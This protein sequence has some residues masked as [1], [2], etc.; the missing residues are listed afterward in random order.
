[1]T[2]KSIARRLAW[3]GMAALCLA[4]GRTAFADDAPKSD[5][6]PMAAQNILWNASFECGVGSGTWGVIRRVGPNVPESWHRGGYRSA[7]CLSLVKPI[8]SRL[9]KIGDKPGTWRL[10]LMARSLSGTARLVVDLNNNNK[11]GSDKEGGINYYRRAFEVGEEWQS[12]SMDVQVGEVVRPYFHL[13]LSGEGVLVDEVSLYRLEDPAAKSVAGQPIQS[14]ETGFVVPEITKVYLDGEKRLCRLL[15]TNNTEGPIETNVSYS[16]FDAFENPVR[17]EKV[18]V[19]LAGRETR[20]FPVD[21]ENL[22]YGAYRLRSSWGEAPAQGDALVGLLP[23]VRHDLPTRWGCNASL[24]DPSL[25][26]SIRMM[27]RLGMGFVST[28]STGSYLGRWSLVE[29]EPGQ[30]KTRLDIARK[31][32]ENDIWIAAY[33]QA[34]EWP[35]WLIQKKP[36]DQEV[37]EAF[38]KYVAA[39]IKAYEPYVKLFH[40]EDET[41]RKSQLQKLDFYAALHKHAYDTAKKTAAE[42]G[43][44]I[45]FSTN[46]VDVGWFGQIWDKIGEGYFDFLSINT[47]HLPTWTV[48]LLREQAKRNSHERI[49][50]SPAIGQ[51]CTMRQTTLIQDTPSSGVPPTTFVWQALKT[52]WL[53]RPYGLEAGIFAPEIHFGFYE[54][55]VHDVA[56]Y[57]P[58]QGWTGLEYDNSPHAGFQAVTAMRSLIGPMQPVRRTLG[59]EV[60]EAGMPL[61]TNQD[62]EAYPFRNQTGAAVAFMTAS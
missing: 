60:S 12:F 8:G 44:E 32:K 41:E 54:I 48:R 46:T 51:K 47:T 31:L 5:S 26:F 50:F 16:I 57:I 18:A 20:E 39:Y 14:V 49:L 62:F 53:S 33:L 13:E 34:A 21:L 37:I 27:K 9:Y 19:K 59:T 3:L 40:I 61:G 1:M 6:K 25:D 38:G 28:L 58:R 30:L 55:R 45:L 52:S 15:V 29:P 42:L 4:G 7:Y 56:H 43:R 22:K 24:D 10:T 35:S 17:T 36:T 2:N 11:P 23:A